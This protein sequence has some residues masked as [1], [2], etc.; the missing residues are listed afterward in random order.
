MKDLAV[1]LPLLVRLDGSLKEPPLCGTK[2]NPDHPGLTKQKGRFGLDRAGNLI[3]GYHK[4]DKPNMCKR[5][6]TIPVTTA[7][8]PYAVPTFAIPPLC[9]GKIVSNKTYNDRERKLA[10]VNKE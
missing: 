9:A 7:K 2:V 4:T 5:G 8:P 10:E 1:R 3:M 6:G